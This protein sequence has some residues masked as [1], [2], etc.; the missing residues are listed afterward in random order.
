MW[1]FRTFFCFNF[2]LEFNFFEHFRH[3]KKVADAR[4]YHTLSKLA[5]NIYL[6]EICFSSLKIKVLSGSQETQKTPEIPGIQEMAG[7]PGI[8]GNK[9]TPGTP[10]IRGNKETQETPETR[11]TP[12]IQEIQGI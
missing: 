10:E 2:E 5:Y 6:A 12:G 7:T 4:K 1:H 3:D 9:E 11:R 8:Q